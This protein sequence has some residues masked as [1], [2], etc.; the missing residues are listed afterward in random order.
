MENISREVIDFYTFDSNNYNH[1]NMLSYKKDICIEII[2]DN[3]IIYSSG[4]VNGCLFDSSTFAKSKNKFINSQDNTVTFTVRN[5]NLKNEV[6]VYGQKLRNGNIIFISTSLNLMTSITNVI[7]KQ[8]IYGTVVVLVISFLLAYFMSKKI[9]KP[10]V[11]I[12]KESKKMAQ[13]NYDVSFDVSSIDEINELADTLNNTSKELAK[14]EKLRR[15]LLANVS[16]DLKTP[17]TLIKANA[18]MV[19]DI[20]Y[21]NEEKRNNNLDVIINETDRLN[22]LVEDILVLSK[23]QSGTMEL[24]IKKFNLNDLLESILTS[25]LR[26]S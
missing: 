23:T 9:S 16:H 2:E 24:E 8:F 4:A 15:E 26:G 11:K 3:K 17:L 19:K 18:E 6:L 13:G 25:S 10:I 22:M 20:T 14:T 12:N 1:L 21:Q 7:E 5:I